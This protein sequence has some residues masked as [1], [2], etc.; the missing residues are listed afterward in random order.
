MER[1]GRVSARGR[2]AAD[3]TMNHLS[4]FPSSLLCKLNQIPKQPPPPSVQQPLLQSSLLQHGAQ[5]GGRSEFCGHSMWS[6]EGGDPPCSGHH[7]DFLETWSYRE[8]VA[9]RSRRTALQQALPFP[10]ICTCTYYRRVFH[11][12]CSWGQMDERS[13]VTQV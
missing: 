1:K 10:C 12:L 3:N 6:Q 9:G 11:H 5:D 13:K 8:E 2:A 7:K 4:L